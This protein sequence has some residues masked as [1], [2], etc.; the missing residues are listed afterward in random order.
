MTK[1]TSHNNAKPII[2]Y[3]PGAWGGR[4]DGASFWTI[5]L[6]Q[7]LARRLRT[8]ELSWYRIRYRGNSLEEMAIHAMGQLRQIVDLAQAAGRPLWV[9]SYSMGA[10][11]ARATFAL[12]AANG[13]TVVIDRLLEISPCPASGITRAK[14]FSLF[15][16]APYSLCLSFITGRLAVRTVWE[17]KRL[18]FSG[19]THQDGSPHKP[20]VDQFARDIVSFSMRDPE[21]LWQLGCQL[22]LRRV[23]CPRLSSRHHVV[24]FAK[25]NDPF[26]TGLDDLGTPSPIAVQIRLVRSHG[27][28]LWPAADDFKKAIKLLVNSWPYPQP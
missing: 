4:S 2:V 19:W 28:L 20:P 9:I 22:F 24:V 15:R 6:K 11:V 17:A 23:D 3:W 26:T 21:P 8:L 10:Q 13:E 14:L 18:F 7:E 16:A 27:S 1:P 25:D 5:R 12:A